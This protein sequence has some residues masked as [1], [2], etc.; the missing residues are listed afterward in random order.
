MGVGQGGMHAGSPGASYGGGAGRHAH[1]VTRWV[2][3]GLGIGVM[4]TES[5]CTRGLL[6]RHRDKGCKHSGSF[7]ASQGTGV[8]ASR[9]LLDATGRRRQVSRCITWRKNVH[10]SRVS[11]QASR[12]GKGA[13]KIGSQGR[14]WGQ[15]GV[16]AG[17]KE[18]SVLA[19]RAS[20]S[21]TFGG[22]GRRWRKISLLGSSRAKARALG[23]GKGCQMPGKKRVLH[24]GLR[25]HRV[26]CSGLSFQSTEFRFRISWIF[27]VTCFQFPRLLGSVS[28]SL[29][30][31]FLFPGFSSSVL[32]SVSHI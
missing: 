20:R 1:R 13:R 25:G 12:G 16:P 24:R 26:L 2:T 9:V 17:S 31:S 8:Y 27:P 22:L 19:R 23:M 14:H 30:F 6:E 10:P 11:I 18:A 3:G 32:D 15:G 29:G 4:H 7:G 5:L 28:P 21:V